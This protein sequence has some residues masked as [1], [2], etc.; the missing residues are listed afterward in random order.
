MAYPV[1]VYGTPGQEKETSTTKKRALGTVLR[2][3]N[4]REYAYSLNG[5]VAL[6]P[7]KIVATPQ[8]TA[9]HD[10]D[11]VTAANAVGATTFVATL[12]ATAAV[13]DLYTD[14]SVFVNAVG[15]A[16]V[17]IVYQIDS[18]EAVDAGGVITLKL[19]G[20]EKIITAT[21][22]DSESSIRPNSYANIV[23]TPTTVLNRT[24]GVA[25]VPVA[26]ASY[27]WVQTKGPAPVLISGTVVVGQH[28]RAAGATTAGA[29]MAL[30][31]DGSAEDEQELGVV[32]APISVTTD[33]GW[34]WLNI[35]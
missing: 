2:T 19:A 21:D 9:N 33:Y 32:M 25:T 12:G 20:T 27:C 3:G 22:T 28:I 16:G 15:T 8:P 18:H 30:N 29:V 35:A 14:G 17:G 10:M 26:A 23:V 7:G 5:A 24:V 34:V 13:K 11:L 31:R 6:A 4:G 1:D